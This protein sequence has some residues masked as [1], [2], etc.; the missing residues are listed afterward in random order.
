MRIKVIYS[1]FVLGALTLTACHSKQAPV[2]EN[3]PNTSQY[4]P[5]MPN[6]STV[7]KPSVDPN[8]IDGINVIK[9]NSGVIKAKGYCSQGK[10]TGEWQCFYEDGKMWS[11]EFFTNG[12]PDGTISV[13]YDNGKQWYAGQYRN[14]KPVGIWKFWDKNGTLL[15]SP[16]YDKKG[17]NTAM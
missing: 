7:I 2:S 10:K 3:K 1:L 14:G 15:R 9:Y 12:Y 8:A 16:N 17:T 11:D 4:T 6:D 5:D 13:W